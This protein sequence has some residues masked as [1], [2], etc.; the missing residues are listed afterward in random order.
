MFKSKTVFVVGAGAS[1]ELNLPIGTGLKTEVAAS[2]AV[3]SQNYSQFTNDSVAEALAMYQQAENDGDRPL[4]RHEIARVA[5]RIAVNMPLAPS[6]DNFINSHRNNKTIVTVSKIAI[7]NCILRAERA[8]YLFEMHHGQ[9]YLP[10]THPLFLKAWHIPLWQHLCANID[11][12]NVDRIFDNVSFIVFNYDRC[13][14]HFLYHSL[15]IYYHIDEQHAAEII[16]RAT[17]IHPYGQVGELPF[18]K[19]AVTAAF[20][21]DDPMTLFNIS[22]EIRT[23]M[24]S[25]HEGVSSQMK[26]VIKRAE[27]LVT[28][29]FGFVDQNIRLLATDS[30]IVRAFMTAYGNSDSDIEMAASKVGRMIGRI[31]LPG[32]VGYRQQDQFS[33]YVLNGTCSQLFAAHHL[34]MPEGAR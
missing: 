11:A 17:I 16:R 26:E 1:A 13:L 14:E 33:S 15:R 24:E 31:P 8:S 12:D 3:N 32:G 5:S 25:I 2:L 27:T 4:D 23:F 30:S 21:E 7:A 22:S 20:G 28:L 19:K 29:G 10:L 9:Y 6:I 18:S 34:R